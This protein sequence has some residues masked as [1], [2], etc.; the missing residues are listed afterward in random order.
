MGLEEEKREFAVP[1]PFGEVHLPS[2]EEMIPKLEA[3]KMD[4]RRQRALLHGI[5]VDIS[6]I[7]G[8]VPIVGDIVADVVEDLHGAELRR[9]LTGKEMDEF[10]IQD[11]V[12]PSTI[13]LLRTFLKIRE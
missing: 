10:M 5:A 2:F 9:T 4:E 6:S 7:I 12:A 8:W 13:A 1:T 11:K 3:P